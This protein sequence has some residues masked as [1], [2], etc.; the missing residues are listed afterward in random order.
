[1]PFARKP[2][3]LKARAL[4]ALAL[5][6]HSRSELRQKL[7]RPPR[8]AP[9]GMP[10]HTG[11]PG[12]PGTTQASMLVE[13]A[14]EADTPCRAVE[15]E[16]LLDE[17]QAQGLLNEDRFIES[18]VHAR[19]ARFG[20]RRIQAELAQHGLELDAQTAQNLRHTELERARQVWAK[21]FGTQEAQHPPPPAEIAR[22]MRFLAAR[23]FSPEVIHR[24]IKGS[25]SGD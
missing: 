20:N 6:E 3:S 16:A 19:S 13:P 21:R 25:R 14:D 5:R 10:A 9:Q 1:V 11:A 18:R 2:L 12:G 8:R 7:L 22:Q 17:L 15:V 24:I 4:Q 23:G